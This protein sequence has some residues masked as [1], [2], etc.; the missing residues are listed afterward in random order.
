MLRLMLL[1]WLVMAVSLAAADNPREKARQQVIDTFQVLDDVPVDVDPEVVE[2]QWR[3]PPVDKDAYT[4]TFDEMREQWDH[5]MRGL[6]IPYPSPEYLEKRYRRFPHLLHEMH[7]QDHDWEQHSLNVLEVWH[8]FFRGDFQR[9][10]ELGIHYG[11][12]A[13]VPGV[14]AQI[15]HAVYV[16]ETR[17][18]MKMHLRDAMDRIRHYGTSFPFLSREEEFRDD[19][20]MMRLGLAYAVGRLAEDEPV[21]TTLRVGYVPMM[22][23]ASVDLLAVAPE[24]PVAL[25]LDAGFDAHV[26]RRLGQGLGRVTFGARPISAREHFEQALEIVDDMAVLHY[27]YANS[28]LYIDSDAH[29]DQALK[30]LDKAV[31]LEPLFAM[32]QLDILHAEKRLEEVRHWKENGGGNYRAFDRKRRRAQRGND[33]NAYSVF[34]EP[35]TP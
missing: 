27:E 3:A 24:H 10:R 30:H 21:A 20:V 14:F 29:V 12:Y 32:E 17:T 18:E 26:I 6:R 15:L 8:A 4:L 28:L 13:Q 1:P 25:A 22:L 31:S 35:F 9:A 11:G 5:L 2:G 33:E 16:A 19:Y 34:H 7:H 23:N